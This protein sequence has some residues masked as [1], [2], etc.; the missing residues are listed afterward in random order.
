MAV[1]RGRNHKEG[2]R[3]KKGGREFGLT[4]RPTTLYCVTFSGRV[5][6]HPPPP[7]SLPH[8]HSVCSPD[9]K[10]RIGSSQ[11]CRRC[12]NKSSKPVQSLCDPSVLG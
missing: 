7:C 1:R 5:L 6:L 12:R 4:L 8:P 3:E 2:R 11:A 10:C 9:G